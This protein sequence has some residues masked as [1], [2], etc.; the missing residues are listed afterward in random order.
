MNEIYVFLIGT[1]LIV[2]VFLLL[3]LGHAFLMN[4]GFFLKSGFP[5]KKPNRQ[6]FWSK[7]KEVSN[8]LTIYYGLRLLA[9][10]SIF[11][12]AIHLFISNK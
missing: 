10:T 7:E 2:E 5:K 6:D 4:P 11:L 3:L 12:I 1:A 8:Q 9:A